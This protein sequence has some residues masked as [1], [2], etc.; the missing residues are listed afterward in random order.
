MATNYEIGP[1]D[2][3]PCGSG[4]KYKF[5]CASKAKR[6]G[7]FPIGTVAYYGPDDKTTTKIAAGVVLHEDAEPIVER[8]IATNIIH[9]VAIQQ[10]VMRFFARHGVKTVAMS[11]GIIG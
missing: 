6:H 2:P 9:D 7:K 5:C 8:W 11:G 1:Y 3:C 10:E 4:A